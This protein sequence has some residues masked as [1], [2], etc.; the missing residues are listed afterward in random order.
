MKKNCFECAYCS[1]HYPSMKDTC[2]LDDHEIK[3]AEKE[4]CTKFL[5][6]ETDER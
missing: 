1:E 6:G 5:K 2:D 3:D 4:Y